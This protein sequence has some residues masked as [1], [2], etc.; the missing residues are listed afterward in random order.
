MRPINPLTLTFSVTAACQ[1]RCQTCNIGNVYLANPKLAKLLKRL[2]QDDVDQSLAAILTLN[3]IAHTVG[4]I[5]SGAK[6]TVVFGSAWFGLF[7]AVMTLLILFLSEIVPKTLGAVYWKSLARPTATL[8]ASASPN[9]AMP[10]AE[11]KT[12][13]R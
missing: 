6:A 12:S 11:A 3:T 13:W 2:K 1:S 5:G 10:R 9:T 4:A 8:A 7:S